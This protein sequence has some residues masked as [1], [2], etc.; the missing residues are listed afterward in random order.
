MTETPTAKKLHTA[1]LAVQKLGLKAKK[2]TDA[3]NYK[4]A[5]L[6]EVWGVLNKPLADN[7]I[8]VVQAPQGDKL[9]TTIT[10]AETGESI[11]SELPLI[12]PETSKNHMQDLGGA[13]TYARRYALTSMF[14]II[15]EDDDNAG[16]TT[17]APTPPKASPNKPA[18]DKQINLARDLLTR[19]IK[20]EERIAFVKETI[21]KEKPET[22]ADASK[23]I[24]ALMKQP[25][26]EE[27][28]NG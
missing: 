11:T 27:P 14:N 26:A 23:L 21:G 1:L 2:D 12:T 6:E 10:L 15:T 25:S 16:A 13:I 20:A 4:Y 7:G 24:D 28:S 22:S 5:D 3:Y 8:V 19:K 9:I 17:D 18:S